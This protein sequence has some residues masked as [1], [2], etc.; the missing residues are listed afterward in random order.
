[1]SVADVSNIQIS[2]DVISTIA[3]VA[4]ME[5]EGVHSLTSSISSNIKDIIYKK[6]ATKGVSVDIDEENNVN[7]TINMVIKY[8]YKIQDVAH[9]VQSQVIRAVSDMTNL[10]IISVNVNVVG[11][12]IPKEENTK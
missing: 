10:E 9:S 6:G 3:S 2:N 8:N 1:M 4:A 12:N 5:V 7:I 11:V